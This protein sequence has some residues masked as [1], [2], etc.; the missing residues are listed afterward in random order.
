MIFHK[1]FINKEA[2][3]LFFYSKNQKELSLDL[4]ANQQNTYFKGYEYTEAMSISY[5]SNWEDAKFVGIGSYEDITFS[6]ANHRVFINK[7]I[8]L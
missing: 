7:S 4:H 3:H 6:P 1:V 5:C 2:T 8:K